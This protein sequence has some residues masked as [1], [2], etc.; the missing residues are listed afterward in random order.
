M[1]I[2]FLELALIVNGFFLLGLWAGWRL[3]TA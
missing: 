2:S 1:H 3:R